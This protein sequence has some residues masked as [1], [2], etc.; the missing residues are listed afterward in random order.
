MTTSK[1][2]PWVINLAA[3]MANHAQAIAD[4]KDMEPKVLRAYAARMLNNAE[5]LVYWAKLH[6]DTEGK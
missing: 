4:C 3:S 5:T 2:P 6:A 1:T